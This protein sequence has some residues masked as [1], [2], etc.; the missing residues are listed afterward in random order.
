MAFSVGVVGLQLK[1][2]EGPKTNPGIL[3]TSWQEHPIL[4]RPFYCIHPCRTAELLQTLAAPCRPLQ[5]PCIDC[6]SNALQTSSMPV[7]SVV[8]LCF[9]FLFYFFVKNAN[10]TE[11]IS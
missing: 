1:L 3:H 10:T 6:G 4:Q 9:L 8:A 2:A 5:V 11:G 7:I